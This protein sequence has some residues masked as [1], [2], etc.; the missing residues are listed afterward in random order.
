[1]TLLG[2][3]EYHQCTRKHKVKEHWFLNENTITRF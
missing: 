2:E 3:V 1:M